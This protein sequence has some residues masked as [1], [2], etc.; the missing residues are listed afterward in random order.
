[1]FC[2]PGHRLLLCLLYL[3]Q[4]VPALAV[5]SVRGCA[6]APGTRTSSPRGV[7]EVSPR[8]R[9]V[10]CPAQ[11]R[12]GA[13]RCL[14]PSEA[15]ARARPASPP[16]SPVSS[17]SRCEKTARFPSSSDGL[18]CSTAADAPAGGDDCVASDGVR[19]PRRGSRSPGQ[20][21]PADAV[22]LPAS[23]KSSP[24]PPVVTASG[25]LVGLCSLPR[26]RLP[27]GEF[28]LLSFASITITSGY[29]GA[30]VLTK[31]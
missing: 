24:P 21:A 25:S 29:E 23:G 30:R 27:P 17:R 9:R 12:R 2:P 18:L 14:R 16:R 28:F 8:L 13:T 4:P 10:P 19:G 26:L 6:R 7:C 31:A 1:M 3:S 22:P 20:V 15:D 11:A 5:R